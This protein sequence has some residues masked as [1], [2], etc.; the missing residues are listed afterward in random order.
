MRLSR[1]DRR[2]WPA[3]AWRTTIHFNQGVIRMQPDERTSKQQKK[4][5]KQS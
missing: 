4:P 3:T 2:E 5:E 1:T